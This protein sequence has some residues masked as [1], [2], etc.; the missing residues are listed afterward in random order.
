VGC[1]YTCRVKDS[2]IVLNGIAAPLA[3][4]GSEEEEK[5]PPQMQFL[6]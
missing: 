3:H 2:I 6:F 5:T 1:Q 4:A